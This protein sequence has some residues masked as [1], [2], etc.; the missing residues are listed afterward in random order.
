MSPRVR[1]L[2]A[3]VGSFALAAVLLYLALRG[4]DFDSMV[5]TI[6]QGDYRWL[7]PLTV[8]VVL[9]HVLRAWRW[10]M[11]LDALPIEAAGEPHRRVTLRLAFYSVM[12]G[13]MV[14]YAAPR[15]GEVAR[16]VNLSTRSGL[17]FSGVF[18]TVVVERILDVIVLAVA[19]VSVFFILLDRS[20]TVHDLFIAPITA[21]L[22]RIPALALL[23][24]SVGVA[25]VVVL[26]YRQVVRREDSL[27]LALWNRRMKPV[28][29]S[30]KDGLFTLTRVRQP[31][32]LVFSTLAMWFCYLLMAYL[33]F[34]MLGMATPYALGLVDAWAVMAI[35]AIGVVI[36]SPGGVGS[37]HYITIQT[38]VHLFAVGQEEAATYAVL[39][40][41][42][43]LVLYVVLGAACL[44]LQGSSL[45]EL[46]ARTATT[47]HGQQAS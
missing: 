13:Y 11:L 23:G 1:S 14:N 18:G 45:R 21:Q 38:L 19:L 36:P 33:P 37:Y 41:A 9:S 3:Q 12:I 16:T 2:I 43:Q 44:M 34:V 28:L 4:V 30:F 26:L 31:G 10:Q 42:A 15:L 32:A 24:L 20:A 8:V 17:R 47:Q 27:L 39:S 29:A 40:H 5:A 25:L 6:R 7:V 35:G 46:S 22:G